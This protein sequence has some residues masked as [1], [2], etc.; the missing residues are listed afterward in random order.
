MAAPSKTKTWQYQHYSNPAG[1]IPSGGNQ[2]GAATQDGENR[3]VLWNIKDKLVN[4]TGTPWTVVASS[5]ATSAGAADYWTT[6]NDV[7]FKVTTTFSWIVL[8]QTGIASNFQICISCE[9]DR[10]QAEILTVAVSYSAGFSG[11]TTSARPTATDEYTL[12]NAA[13]W[14][15][16]T[17]SVN[18]GASVFTSSD[19]A[20]TRV[21]VSY[22]ATLTN[23]WLFEKP[24]ATYVPTWWTTPHVCA[25]NHTP[26]VA[27]ITGTN[28]RTSVGAFNGIPIA[29]TSQAYSTATMLVTWDRF[30]G[31]DVNSEWPCFPAGL[32]SANSYAGGWLGTLDDYW[33]VSDDLVN[34]DYF[35]GD[36]SKAFVVLGDV[37]QPS[38]G[39]AVVI[40]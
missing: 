2:S 8:K 33:L 1:T 38:D 24:N 32:F 26:V 29:L 15:Q 19:G 14:T 13:A 28:Y 6:P 39:S 25:M 35:P 5:N 4:A 30:G 22:S 23:Y 20:C 40:D 12:H 31:V 3:M 10:A 34:G 37:L 21:Y 9:A 7:L 27:S 17:S 18:R 36:G 11:G 16:G